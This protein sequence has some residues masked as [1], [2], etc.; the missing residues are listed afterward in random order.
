MND[1]RIRSAVYALII[2]ALTLLGERAATFLG[3]EAPDVGIEE[4]VGSGE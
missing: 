3:V 1:T 2:A 4:A